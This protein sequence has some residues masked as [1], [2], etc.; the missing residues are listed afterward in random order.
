MVLL[1][2]EVGHR[3]PPLPTT[4]HA[5]GKRHSRPSTVAA[6]VGQEHRLLYVCDRHS[7]RRFLVDTG[8]EIS[9]LPPTGLDTRSGK[10]GP[11]LTAANNSSIKTYGTRTIPLHFNSRHFKWT[12]TIADVS[13]PLLGA[14]F[15]R[16]HSLL[17]DVKGRRLVSSSTF[18]SISLRHADWP[19]PR[20]GSVTFSD[21]KYAKVL[22]DFPDIITPQ[23]HSTMPKHGVAHH[24]PTTGPPLHARARRLPP[25][26]LKQAKEEFRK[27]EEMG[28]V[29]RS[30]SPWASPLHMVPKSSGGWRPCGDYRRLNEVTTADRYPV[31]HIQD[32]TGNLHGAK[33]FSKVDLV[34]GYHQ[35]P[36]HP[37]DISKTAIITP[38]G[39]FEFLRMPFGLK[40][41]AQAFQRLMDKVGRGL[42]FVFIYLDDIL[43]ASR[44]QTEHLEHLRQLFQRLQEHGLAINLSKCQFGRTSI[45]FLGHRVNQHGAV[46]LPAKVEAIRKFPKPATLK[47]L[48]EFVGMVTFYHRFVPSA[49]RI[50]EPLFKIL[51]GKP[52]ELSWDDT[53]TAAFGKAKEALAKATMLVHPQSNA[54]MALTVDA[55]DTAVGGVLEQLINGNWQPLSFFSRRLRTPERKYSAFDRELLA[56]YLAIR[57]F[58]YFLEGRD[59][60][61]F[62]DHKP[63]TFA[64]AKVSDPWSARQQRHLAY[65]SEYTTRI[66]HVSGKNNKVADAL[67]RTSINNISTFSPDIDYTALA[68][69]QEQDEEILAFRTAVTGLV[70]ED[71]R[72]GPGNAT[73]LCDVSTGQPRPI[74]PAAWRRR[75]FE[76]IHGLAHPSIRAT[77][78][79]MAAKYVWHGLRKQVGNWA[80]A[81]IPCQTSKIQRHTKAPLQSFT[82]PD[83]RFDHIHV[84]IVGP[85]P[86]SRGNTHL[87]TIIDRF[88]RWP[89]AIPLSDTSTA[90]C[91]RA[92]ITHWVARFGVPVDISSDRGAQFT[93]GLWASVTR[94]LGA[95]LHHTTA[96]HP[97]ANGLVERFHRHLKTALKARLTGPDWMDELPWVLLGIRTAPKEDLKTSSA[98]LVYGAPLTVPGD[99]IPAGRGQQE[100]PTAVLTRLRE[101]VGTL[102]PVPTSRHSLPARYVPSK[103]QDS[104]YVFI[105]R[106][107]LRTPL[108][109]PYEGPFRVLQKNPKTFIVDYG[110]RH[111][112]VSVDRLKPAHLDIDEPVRV[113]QPRPRGRPPSRQLPPS[114][115]PAQS[116]N[117]RSGRISRQ[118]DR[119]QYSGSG[120]GHVAAH[121][122]ELP[123]RRSPSSNSRR[124]RSSS[125][126]TSS[127]HR[128]RS[129]STLGGL[130]Y[131]STCCCT[132]PV[133]SVFAS[134]PTRQHYL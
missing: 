32:F 88:T 59:F 103:L 48:Q 102:S 73:L 113:A 25:D 9:V 13:Q 40:N 14:D 96:Y 80:R 69:A 125:Q 42:D 47:A 7:G 52:K 119:L 91:A 72:F 2:P 109:K 133:E 66:Q 22:A 49:A 120:G 55:S 51:A 115:Q 131:E 12:F 50:M 97:Q 75:I 20:L 116:R 132:P 107:T 56:L 44:S 117:T 45:D 71:V 19:A 57:H 123:N 6:A 1:S 114:P 90:T 74:V 8:A 82:S 27:M 16:E 86:Q 68:A 54:P 100:S 24:I 85:L 61:A 70:L 134:Q 81:C 4:L 53:A 127:S 39:L 105:R 83:R 46:P 29:R 34:R 104:Q 92:L 62:T 30:D 21:N 35:I 28:I 38:F 43:V 17:V 101:K 84:D 94:L 79:L 41:A 93:S 77:K 128:S 110:G 64:F 26:K 108:Q 78:A 121:I 37:D 58:R 67:S 99:F 126:H 124:R 10:K 63:L 98:E 130:A 23:F 33:V 36:V 76:T 89:E 106:D 3:C 15:L 111:E 5:S 122:T 95:K 87:L 31:P 129:S 112:T 118:P 18:E 11:L 65:I 60:T